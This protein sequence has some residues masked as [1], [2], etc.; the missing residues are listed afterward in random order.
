MASQ[1]KFFNK[2]YID[3]DAPN[4]SISVTDAVA[5][6]NGSGLVDLM[7][8]RNNSSAWLTT[9]STD[10]ANTTLVF[11]MSE[12]QTVTDLILVVH[13]LKAFTLKYWN[14]STY[15]DFST[16]ISETTNTE[17]TNFYS[18]TAVDTSR[19]QLV[20]TGAQVADDDKY[21]R[22]MIVTQKLISGQFIGW[23]IIKSM[24]HNTSKQINKMLSGKVNIVQAVGAVSFE[25]SVKNWNIDADLKIIEEI[26][27]GR[28]GV[29]VS[30]SG[31]DE[32]QFSHL[33]IGYRKQDIYLM[34]SINDYSPA[35]V[36]GIYTNGIKTKINLAE[37]VD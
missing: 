24:V 25:L 15:V 1:I 18:F 11:D 22:Q 2:S 23:P 5:T 27:F 20:I 4:S 7:R 36:S 6:D 8:N 37:S 19:I 10:A 31:G 21:I 35:W 16:P 13:N 32:A 29:L 26:F 14:G 34:R 17:T 9:G 12:E 33:R 28:K 3:I 30:L